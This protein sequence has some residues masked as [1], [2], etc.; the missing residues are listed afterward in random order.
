MTE[1]RADLSQYY[2]MKAVFERILGKSSFAATK[3][4][5]PLRVWKTETV[6]LLT[7][8]SLAVRDTVEIVDD[9][10]KGE[11]T[12]EIAE[13]IKRIKSSSKID[14][15]FAELSA[16]LTHV[17]FLQLGFIPRGHHRLPRVLL[18]RGHWKLDVV[19]SVQYVQSTAQ[20]KAQERLASARQRDSES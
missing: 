20:L 13:G 17:I 4:Y 8:I 18:A 5:A 9:E 12:A 1:I 11:M 6:R 19:R 16:T 10:W 14:E 15:L 2:A 7:A 3:D